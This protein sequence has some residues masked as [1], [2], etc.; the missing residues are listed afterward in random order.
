MKLRLERVLEN[1]ESNIDNHGEYNECK[2]Q[3]E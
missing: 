2:T 1:L 3:L